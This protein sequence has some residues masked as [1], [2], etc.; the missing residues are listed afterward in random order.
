[1]AK[2]LQERTDYYTPSRSAR[3]PASTGAG[4]GGADPE[5]D[6]ATEGPTGYDIILEHFRRKYEPTFRRDT[7]LYSTALGRLVKPAEACYAPGRELVEKLA[8]AI[9]APRNDSGVKRGAL[10]QFFRTWAPSAWSDLLDS[11][12]EE[13]SAAEISDPAQEEFRNRVSRA[14]HTLVSFG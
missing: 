7:Y 4:R 8:S 14:L 5:P 12:S 1:I 2:A 11:L 13:E 6:T 10:P 3:S 9:D